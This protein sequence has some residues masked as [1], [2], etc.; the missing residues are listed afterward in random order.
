MSYHKYKIPELLNKYYL[1][2]ISLPKHQMIQISNKQTFKVSTS[3][4]SQFLKSSLTSLHFQ[5]ETFSLLSKLLQNFTFIYVLAT[6][7][8]CHCSITFSISSALGGF[9]MQ[10]WETASLCPLVKV[11]RGQISRGCILSSN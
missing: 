1:F 2:L 6:S 3:T 4:L 7:T 5:N 8:E 11:K 10:G 9:C